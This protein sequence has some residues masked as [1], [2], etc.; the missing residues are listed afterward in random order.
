MRTEVEASAACV[1]IKRQSLPWCDD[2]AGSLLADVGAGLRVPSASGLGN[3]QPLVRRSD[4]GEEMS[5][6]YVRS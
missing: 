1:S 2:D 3:W 6:T 5:V 4:V